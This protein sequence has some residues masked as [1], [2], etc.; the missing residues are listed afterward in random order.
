MS[1]PTNQDRYPFHLRAVLIVILLATLGTALSAASS[2]ASPDTDRSAPGTTPGQVTAWNALPHQ[3]LN[4]IVR[5]L[6]VFGSDL[7]VGG[8]FSAT[9]DETTATNLGNIARYDTAARTWHALP[10]QG[11]N[12]TV[13]A[14]AMVGSD[15][16]VGGRFDATGDGATLTNLGNIARYDT[17]AKTWHALPNQGLSSV[18]E[19]LALVGSDLY[20][21][22]L[23]AE[24]GDGTTLTNL[25]RIARYDITDNTWHAL[26]NEGL[27]NAVR[28]L[29]AVGSDL[30][31]G[32]IFTRTGDFALPSYLGRIARYDTTSNT[33]HALPNQ[34]LNN[35]VYALAPFGGDLYVGGYFWETG[36]HATLTNLGGI[37]RYDI[38]ADTWHA[39]PSQGVD[40]I[41]RALALSGSDLYVGGDFDQTGDGTTLTNLGN[42]ARYD[43]AASTWHA[44][45]NQG[46]DAKLWTLAV[47]GS[48]LYVGG[49]FH[50]TGDG[51]TLTDLGHIARGSVAMSRTHLPLVLR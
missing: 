28:V 5:V 35:G 34:G 29:A 44:L 18:V 26:P 47:S 50:Q 17:A 21:G 24:T 4:G 3:G 22:G 23:F 15:L 39:L 41:V 48:D 7:Y 12:G 37:A 25:G 32:G 13:E 40:N 38:A 46:L 49:Y 33:W 16:Y 10:N 20:V 8:N 11:L 2:A 42:V 6:A 14:L 1:Q 31:V 51:T 9:G 45:P 36:D 19:A 43:I 30:Y 27:S